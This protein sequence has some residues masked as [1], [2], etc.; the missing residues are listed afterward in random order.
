MRHGGVRAVGDDHLE[1][2]PLVHLHVVVPHVNPVHVQGRGRHLVAHHVVPRAGPAQVHIGPKGRHHRI[3]VQR[4]AGR[5][6]RGVVLVEG[7]VAVGVNVGVEI[8]LAV[9]VEG[10]R[11]GDGPAAAV[12]G[13]VPSGGV[14]LAVV[15][16]GDV[17]VV[18]LH[19]AIARAAGAV[20]GHQL[21]VAQMDHFAGRRHLAQF[22]GIVRGTARGGLG[23]RAEGQEERE[24]GRRV[25]W[26]HSGG[27]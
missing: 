4:E 3:A 17:G 6:V 10:E 27:R 7:D 12:I 14:P 20:G 11:Q 25:A 16:D 1:G 23:M 22:P 15:V 2:V 5:A 13:V 21:G 18:R 9:Q 8:V 26:G 24:E 19:P